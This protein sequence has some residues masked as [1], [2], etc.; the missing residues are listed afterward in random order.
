MLAGLTE[1]DNGQVVRGNRVRT[2]YLPQTPVFSEET[3]ILGYV[4]AGRE[5]EGE[6]WTDDSTAKSLLTRLGFTDLTLDTAALSGGERKRVALARTLLNVSDAGAAA[7]QILILDEPTNHLDSDMVLWLEDYL[8]SWRGVLVLVTHDRHFLDRVTNK[9][10]EIDHGSLY[11][12][13]ANYSGYL[14]QRQQRIET[15]LAADTKRANL[16]RTELAWLH[17]GARARSTK[18]KAHIQRIE[19]LQNTANTVLD[20]TVEMDSVASRMGKKTI[21]IRNVSKI[22]D[23]RLLFED[24]SY[25]VLR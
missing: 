21:E 23:G 16:L 5:A 15:S 25:T 14:E 4:L 13:E 7:N 6:A 9:I 11:T 12:Y 3:T 20:R 10:V 2:A 8:A 18:Q 19:E 17:R 1:P 24:F 22:Y